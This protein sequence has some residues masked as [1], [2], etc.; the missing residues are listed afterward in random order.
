MIRSVCAV[1]ALT[2]TQAAVQAQC[3]EQL[4]RP[5]T[6]ATATGVSGRLL[7]A[8]GTGTAP[9]VDIYDVASGNWSSASLSLAR[10]NLSAASLGT[11]AFFAG[12]TVPS[13]SFQAVH[14][15]RV[16]IYDASTGL[17]STATLSERR[18]S[19]AAQQVG[20]QLVFAGGWSSPA[21]PAQGTATVDIY[22]TTS[23]WSTA[24][25]SVPRVNI[26]STTVGSLALFAGGSDLY[27]T[28]NAVDIYDSASGTWTTATLLRARSNL[29]AASVGS[30]AFFAGGMEIAGPSDLID[31]YDASTGTWRTT[32]LSQPRFGL[33]AATVGPLVLFAGGENVAVSDVV[34]VYDSRTS[35]WFVTRLSS[36]RTRMASAA[37][38][39]VCVF[40]AGLEA[41]AITDTVDV[42]TSGMPA[43]FG[44]AIGACPCG[45]PGTFTTGCRNSLGFGATLAGRGCSRLGGTL[46]LTATGLPPARAA[47]LV[48]GSVTSVSAFG[49]G[50]LFLGPPYRRIR[51]KTSTAAGEVSFGPGAPSLAERAYQVWYRDPS[52]PCGTN[53]NLTT[54]VRLRQG[55]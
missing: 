36:P 37:L 1:L 55:P 19:I 34:D 27:S 30:L 52:G 6:G 15:D 54:G 41:G 8:G 11:Q 28:S 39:D 31:V 46:T 12:G 2:W 48:E 42:F 35:T 7:V 26:A 51:T 45:N 38:G 32:R 14:S 3:P 21:P 40:A 20:N 13:G 43:P 47:V 25:L 9:T 23:G 4:S 53:F 5:R 16:D 18:S 29:A 10:S 44:L 24:T 50:L 49:D 17:W 22:D 33:S